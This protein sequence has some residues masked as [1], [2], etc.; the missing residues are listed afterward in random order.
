MSLF[1]SARGFEKAYLDVVTY[2]LLG[3]NVVI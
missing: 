3:E 2:V 1:P